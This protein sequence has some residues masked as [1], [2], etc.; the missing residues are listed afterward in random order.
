MVFENI[1]KADWELIVDHYREQDGIYRGF[2]FQ[3]ITLDSAYTKTGYWWRY[4]EFPESLDSYS[5]VRTIR[6]TFEMVRQMVPAIGGGTL[7]IGVNIQEATQLLPSPPATQPTFG[8]GP[9]RVGVEMSPTASAAPVVAA[10]APIASVA[11]GATATGYLDLPPFAMLMS[12]TSSQ[13]GWLRIY[14]SDAWAAADASRDRLTYHGA[15]AG[16]IADP[17][18]LTAGQMNLSPPL[19]AYSENGGRLYPFRFTSD[20]TTGPVTI[21][22]TARPL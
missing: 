15:G 13:P 22:V 1:T 7:T 10:A 16:V 17:V 21:T 4:V 2:H 12:I 5:N 19:P 9:L 11:T 20:G 3:S 14:T 8:G 18:F 6:C